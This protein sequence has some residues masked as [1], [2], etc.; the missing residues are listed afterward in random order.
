MRISMMI[1]ARLLLRFT[2]VACQR[3]R[4]DFTMDPSMWGIESENS[5]MQRERESA[6]NIPTS[7][8]TNVHCSSEYFC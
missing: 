8:N 4:L 5:T 3:C 1:C 7:D 2:N 6:R